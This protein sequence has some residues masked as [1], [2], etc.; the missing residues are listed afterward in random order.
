MVYGASTVAS[1]NYAGFEFLRS[2][3]ECATGWGFAA[4]HCNPYNDFDGMHMD[5]CVLLPGADGPI[6]TIYWELCREGVDDCRYVATLQER[7]ARAGRD[8][9]AAARARAVLRPLLDPDAAP[10]REPLAFHRHRW[11]LAR[12]VLNLSERTDLTSSLSFTPAVSTS[13]MRDVLEDNVIENPSFEN[14]PQADGLPGWPYPF[15]DAFSETTGKPT[16]AISVT[17]EIAQDGRCSL[18]WDFAKSE[19]KGSKYGRHSYLIINVQV[20]KEQIPGLRGRRVRAGM[21]VRLGGGTLAPGFNLRMFGTRD[22]KYGYLDGMAYQGGIEDP[23]VWNRYESEGVILPETE[24][25]DIHISCRIPDD[26]EARDMSVFYL[27]AISV[28]PLTPV[29]VT[30]GSPLDEVYVG[31]PIRWRVSTAEP[32]EQL[33]VSLLKGGAVLGEHE[34]RETTEP[35]GGGF[36][37]GKLAPGV[38]R[39]QATARRKETAEPHTAWREIIVAPDPFAW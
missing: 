16:G 8:N 13:P 9:A 4:Y 32:A 18:K 31:E 2:G 24:K 25:M 35:Q 21:W 17:D 11:Q 20:A 10:M 30:I 6:P 28:R 15:E 34:V 5:W 3:A 7:I 1:R 37:T 22:G 12:E 33:T 29:P 27:D 19:G 14:E 38:Y 36:P 39:L 23:A 26:P